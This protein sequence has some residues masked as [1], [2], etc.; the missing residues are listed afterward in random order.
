MPVVDRADVGR[1][2]R[3]ESGRVLATLIRVLGDIDAAEDAVQ[4][5]LAAAL[6]KWPVISFTIYIVCRLAGTY[7]TRQW[8][9]GRTVPEP[10]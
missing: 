3:E 9:T 1:I 10:G 4:D 7:R 6:R 8:G 2:F 5:A